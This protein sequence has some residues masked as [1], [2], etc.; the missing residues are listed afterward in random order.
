MNKLTKFLIVIIIIVIIIS[1]YTYLGVE[2]RILKHFYPMRYS[3]YVYDCASN[4]DIDPLL[5]FAV[6][7]TESNFKEKTVSR[8]GAVGLMQLM[9]N[10]AEEQAK[11]NNLQYTKEKLYEPEYNI[12]LGTEYFASLLKI[13]DNNY[14]LA[15][16]AY[17]AGIGNVN[18]WIDTGKINKDGSDFE[19][20]PFKETNM[21]V[22]KIIR[23]YKI[24]KKITNKI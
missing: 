21:Y 16:A 10:T 7:K 2:E 19:N 9:E 14:I 11:K 15:F 24:Y 23:N 20:I 1:L 18:N 17:N 13:Y 5:I 22:R 4:N 3:E 6:I 12:K 8:S